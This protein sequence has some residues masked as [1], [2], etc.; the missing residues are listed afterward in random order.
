MTF[1]ITSYWFQG[2][3]LRWSQQNSTEEVLFHTSACITFADI[4]LSKASPMAEPRDRVGGICKVRVKRASMGR[5]LIRATNTINLLQM[6]GRRS[7]MNT[8]EIG[9]CSVDGSGWSLQGLFTLYNSSWKSKQ[10]TKC[11]QLHGEE[12]CHSLC[13]MAMQEHSSTCFQHRGVEGMSTQRIGSLCF[14]RKEE[15]RL[16]LLT[17]SPY[18]QLSPLLWHHQSVRTTMGQGEPI[19]LGSATPELLEH[20]T[21]WK[22]AE[23]ESCLW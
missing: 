15:S 20:L 17:F 19:V 2:L 21:S 18:E 6:G 9:I 1:N 14:L 13:S 8:Y 23:K 22:L 5:P 4:S 7:W 10:G 3:F 11:E 12:T 16:Q